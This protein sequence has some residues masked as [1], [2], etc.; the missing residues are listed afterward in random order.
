M[1][2]MTDAFLRGMK[3]AATADTAPMRRTTQSLLSRD[4]VAESWEATGNALRKVMEETPKPRRAATNS[5]R[6]SE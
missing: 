1:T 2:I 6:S 5:P 3:V 4:V